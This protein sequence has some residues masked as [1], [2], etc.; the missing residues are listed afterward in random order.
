MNKFRVM[1]WDISPVESSKYSVDE[2]NNFCEQRAGILVEQGADII[3]LTGFKDGY[4]TSKVLET[5]DTF[6]FKWISRSDN[7]NGQILIAVKESLFDGGVKFIPN[8]SIRK[9]CCS[10]LSTLVELKDGVNMEILGLK[11][12]VGED[13]LSNFDQR[14]KSF[15]DFFDSI[16]D[17]E[18]D[19]DYDEEDEENC[20]PLIHVICGDFANYICMGSLNEYRSYGDY[21]GMPNVWYNLNEIYDFLAVR[22]YKMCDKESYGACMPT[23]EVDGK[24]YPDDHIF[25]SGADCKM[26]KVVEVN[27]DL[28]AHDMVIADIVVKG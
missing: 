12:D 27:R 19:E 13:Y 10:I 25:V 20:V 18:D 17:C 26:C 4:Y 2:Y 28:S 3:V 16:I 24:T 7:K 11:M 9:G 23:H 5:L 6:G 14:Y 15:H 8:V 22:D 21:Q 1:T